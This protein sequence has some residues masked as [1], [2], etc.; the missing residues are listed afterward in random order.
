MA[1]AFEDP[2]CLLVGCLVHCSVSLYFAVLRL[3]AHPRVTNVAVYTVL[4]YLMSIGSILVLT[5]PDLMIV[6]NDDSD[7]RMGCYRCIAEMSKTLMAVT[8]REYKTI[9]IN[10]GACD[11]AQQNNR[12]RDRAQ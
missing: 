5:K 8:D 11:R 3:T 6:R 12:A 2:V 4:F 1:F 7:M 9:G 10:R